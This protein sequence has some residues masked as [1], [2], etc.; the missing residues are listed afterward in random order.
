MLH[1]DKS[2]DRAPAVVLDTPLESAQASQELTAAIMR[3]RA[4]IKCLFSFIP[5]GFPEANR[6]LHRLTANAKISYGAD[7]NQYDLWASQ[8]DPIV[9]TRSELHGL[10][11]IHHSISYQ[12]AAEF[13]KRT[14]Y[15]HRLITHAPPQYD[16]IFR[17][18]DGEESLHF[19]NLSDA[20]AMYKELAS[21]GVGP[22]IVSPV[23][24]TGYSFPGDLC[25]YI[26][27]MKSPYP[28]TNTKLMKVRAQL[29]KY[30]IPG[31]VSQELQQGAGRGCRHIDDW[32][33]V[34]F[35]DNTLA[36]YGYGGIHRELLPPD[37]NI[38]LW[39]EVGLPPL[40]AKAK[41]RAV[42]K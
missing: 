4:P 33:E 21:A 31:I 40:P 2:K 11:G 29:D 20:V 18:V 27:F 41:Q 34:F 36:S 26:V 8:I 9:Y 30:Y 22:V 10:A 42:A 19:H 25:R 17:R 5:N 14:A 37:F 24:T 12:R 23:L 16:K 15:S 6:P 1:K 13:L 35:L 3:E 7:S 32:C 39:K 38:R 28:N